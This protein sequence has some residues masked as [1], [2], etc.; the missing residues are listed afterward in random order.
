MFH[1]V[2]DSI[3]RTIFADSQLKILLRDVSF[4]FHAGDV[5]H[6]G[7]HEGKCNLRRLGAD[8]SAIIQFQTVCSK[9]NYSVS[10]AGLRGTFTSVIC[11]MSAEGRAHPH[12]QG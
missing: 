10:G 6:H 2:L 8:T 9:P 7:G 11:S 1:D 4:I 3:L 12:M 5:G